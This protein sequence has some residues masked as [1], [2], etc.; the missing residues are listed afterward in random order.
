MAANPLPMLVYTLVLAA[1]LLLPFVVRRKAQLA[2]EGDGW[3]T[4]VLA[5]GAVLLTGVRGGLLVDG[6]A[7]LILA[8]LG[9]GLRALAGTLAA[10][11]LL[12]AST[13]WLVR[14]DI[15]SS[16]LILAALACL[17]M[18]ILARQCRFMPLGHAPSSSISGSERAAVAALLVL[19]LAAGLMTGALNVPVS[20]KAAWHHW[21]AYLSPVHPLLAGG[22]PFR[23]FPVQYGMGPTLLLAS[24]CGSDCWSGLYAVTVVANALYL[25]TLGWIALL[26][27]RGMDKASRLLALAALL[28]AVFVWTGYP[29]DWAHPVMTPSVGGL[30]FLPL[31]ALVALIVT[32]ESLAAAELPPSLPRPAVWAGHGLWLLGLAWSPET[33]FFTTLV[34]WPWLALRRADGET[35]QAAKAK[36]LLRGGATGL[37]A[38]IAGYAVLALVFRLVFGSGIALGDFLLYLRFPP[39][40]V[41][42]TPFGAIWLVA[43][44]LLLAGVALM[45]SDKPVARRSLYAC[46]LAALAAFSYFLSRSHDNNVLNLLPFLILVMLAAQAAW[47]TALGSGF[48]RAGLAGIIALTTAIH[49]PAWPVAK[50]ATRIAG[51]QIG[52]SALIRHFA[53]EPQDPAPILPA[54]AAALYSALARESGE[55][56]LLFDDTK[57]MPSADPAKAW[58]G[59]NNLANCLPLPREV[60]RHYVRQGAKVFRRPGWLIVANGDAPFALDLFDAAYDVAASRAGGTYTAYR[61]VP[62][63]VR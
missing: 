5:G 30:R 26:L 53:P 23:D 7:L 18:A 4:V 22:V 51:V 12:A 46:L 54:D 60:I 40:P 28:C 35:S 11:L 20:A 36:A 44:V 59:V 43:A 56:V 25:A 45:R 2:P 6:A 21:G 32:A 14:I 27:M 29:L 9:Y 55:A 57:I 41:P 8:S 24:A 37:V 47:P 17:T 34:W 42:I 61:L 13:W 49:Y 15:P 63:D 62:R 39:G 38:V 58:T 48:M 33:A 10:A 16:Q 1:I 19:G 50:S 31:A 3:L 52:P